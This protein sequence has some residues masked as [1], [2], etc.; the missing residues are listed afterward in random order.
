MKKNVVINQARM[1][2]S[3]LPGK[4]LKKLHDGKTLL[5]LQIERLK[6][7]KKIDDIIIAT[8]CNREDDVV[9]ELAKSMNVKFFRGSEANVLARYY[10]ASKANPS[11]YVI[12]VTSDCPFIDPEILDRSIEKY[13]ESGADYGSNSEFY[14]NGMNVEIFRSKMLD[15]AHHNASKAYEREHVTPYFYTHPEKYTAYSITSEVEY[16]RYRLTVDTPEDF[17]L[18]REV[19]KNVSLIT[20]NDFS[21]NDICSFLKAHPELV[22]INQNI[23]QKKYDD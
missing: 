19:Y 22:K 14:P 13:I 6:K 3:R 8:T 11:Q 17:S 1:T 10:F 18:I 9:E 15:D 21:L 5:H 20:G 7:S 4:I 16:P 2:S 12:R 23:V